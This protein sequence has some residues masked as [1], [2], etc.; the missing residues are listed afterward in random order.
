MRVLGV[1][2]QWNSSVA[3][4]I[5]DAGQVVGGAIAGEDVRPVAFEDGGITDL[6]GSVVN[7]GE[8]LAINNAAQVVGVADSRA[9]LFQNGA[10]RFLDPPGGRYSRANSINDAGQVVGDARFDETSNIR[11]FLYEDGMMRDLGTLSGP[12]SYATDINEHGH[13]V[14]ASETEGEFAPGFAVIHAFLYERGRM[15][16]LGVPSGALASGASAMNDEG[17]VVGY[18]FKQVGES[19]IRRPFLYD[20]ARMLYLDDLI[21]A[22]SDW[23]LGDMNDINN[24]GWIVGTGFNA[25]GEERGILLT[26]LGDTG[27]TPNPIPLPPAA[28]TGL[29]VFGSIVARQVSRW[30]K[31]TQ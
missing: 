27:T 26:P 14:G 6:G 30:R 23:V 10:T 9:F 24:D 11:A 20:D 4:G 19:T 17:Q 28:W 8:A 12:Q 2:P 22:D 5:N 31:P 16:D 1:S 15:L 25:A 21:P 18:A 3:R 29:A 13:V 7:F